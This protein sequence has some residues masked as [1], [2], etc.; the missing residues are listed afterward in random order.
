[1]RLLIRFISLTVVG[2]IGLSACTTQRHEPSEPL[3]LVPT[4][5]PLSIGGHQAPPADAVA[6]QPAT[7][8]NDT[9]LAARLRTPTPRAHPTA[10]PYPEYYTVQPGDTLLVL[11]DRFNTS[12]EE[13]MRL[14]N[15]SNP[16]EIYAGQVLQLP[17]KIVTAYAPPAQILPDSEVVYGPTYKAFDLAAEVRRYN[18]YLAGYQEWVEG[19]L[20]S[21]STILQQVAEDYSIGP[22]VLLALLEFQS[23]WLTT[24]T[25]ENRDFPFGLRDPARSGLYLQASWAANRLN[26]GYYGQLVGRDAVLQFSTGERMRYDPATNPGTAAVTNVLARTTT[27]DKFPLMLGAFQQVY[28]RLFG[29]PWQYDVPILPPGVT[30]PAFRL[31]WRDGEVWHFTGGPHGGW[32]DFSAWASLDFLP[33]DVYSCWPSQYPTIAVAAGTVV[34]SRDGQVILDLDGDG[35]HGTGWSVLYMHMTEAGR[36]TVGMRLQKGDPVGYPSCEGGIA[37]AAHLHIARKY[38]GQWIEADS[39]IPF[40]LSGWRAVA[41]PRAYDGWL[42]RGEEMREAC[43]C[44]NEKNAITG[45]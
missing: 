33:P 9:A 38:N 28:I 15:L 22:R 20:L 19:R 36:V 24:P 42:V 2:F 4:P 41:A 43:A 12:V 10:T 17:Y 14:N 25:P 27:P 5:P 3:L 39:D 32:G 26:Q 7:T 31:P 35:Y 16:H 11:A 45:E 6:T 1:M 37:E 44:R 30:Q 29:D 34:R 23:G 13:L 18:G 8:L 40:V 21:G